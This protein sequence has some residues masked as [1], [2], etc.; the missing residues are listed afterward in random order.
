MQVT[1]SYLSQLVINGSDRGQVTNT[2]T[3]NTLE[4]M[5]NWDVLI[6]E[7]QFKNN[8]LFLGSYAVFSLVSLNTFMYFM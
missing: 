8:D 3:Y 7:S 2:F 5:T 1:F 6:S 4:M